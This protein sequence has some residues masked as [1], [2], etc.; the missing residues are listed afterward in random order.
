WWP[1]PSVRHSM[2]RRDSACCR[3]RSKR[4]GCRCRPPRLVGRQAGSPLW[5]TCKWQRVHECVCGGIKVGPIRSSS[6]V[7]LAVHHYSSPQ[8]RLMGSIDRPTTQD[9]SK[10]VTKL[11]QTASLVPE[12]LLLEGFDV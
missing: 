3:A 8:R 11:T 7:S 12:A 6:F 2:Y 4:L 10:S 5:T 1:W 9:L